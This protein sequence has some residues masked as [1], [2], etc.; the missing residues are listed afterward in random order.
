MTSFCFP[1]KVFVLKVL[2]L[3]K[4]P[5]PGDREVTFLLSSSQAATY[6]YQFNHS[7]VKANPLSI[8]SKDTTS[9]LAGLSSH[10]PFL[11]LNVKHGSCEPVNINF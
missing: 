5:R 7:K 3:A 1:E 11:M 9:E 4:T 10:Y 2:G 6:Y 8:F